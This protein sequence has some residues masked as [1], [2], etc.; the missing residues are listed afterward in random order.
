LWASG[1]AFPNELIAFKAAI[2]K[3]KTELTNRVVGIAV[4]SEDLYR[5]SPMGIAAGEYVGAE[6]STL[7][8]YIGQVRTAIKGTALEGVGVGHVDTW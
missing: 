5:N 3:Y 1:T 6:P 4:G 7:V 2:A 8:D